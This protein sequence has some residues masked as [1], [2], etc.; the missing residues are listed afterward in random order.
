MTRKIVTGRF[1]TREELECRVI[2][3]VENGLSLNKTAR[4]CEISATLAR[5]ILAKHD[6]KN[7]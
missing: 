6:N 7:S 3:Y 2:D 4:H 1:E 5:K